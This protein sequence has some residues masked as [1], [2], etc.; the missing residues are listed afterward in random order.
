[1]LVA[2]GYAVTDARSGE[3]AFH[4]VVAA[5]FDL[6]LADNALPDVG[7]DD[8]R[9]AVEKVRADLPVLVMTDDKRVVG[10]GAV[11]DLGARGY[12]EKP[13]RGLVLL[14]SLERALA[15]RR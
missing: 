10:S 5:S 13:V 7:G 1:M 8:L 4:A 12:V 2:A 14:G 15:S 9:V 6:V 3:A 11:A